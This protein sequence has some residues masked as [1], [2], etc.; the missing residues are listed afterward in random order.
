MDDDILADISLLK[1]IRSRRKYTLKIHKLIVDV[2]YFE[3]FLT[4]KF[5]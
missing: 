3:T 4:R 1:N 5:S 2:N